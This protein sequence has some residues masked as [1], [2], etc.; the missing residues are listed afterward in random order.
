MEYVEKNNHIGIYK[1][2][3]EFMNCNSV[4]YLDNGYFI[5]C[6]IHKII[7]LLQKGFPMENGF[8]VDSNKVESY[9]QVKNVPA[10][11]K[12]Y[13]LLVMN[14]SIDDEFIAVDGGPA[15]LSVNAIV[16]V[17]SSHRVVV[18]EPPMDF[19]ANVWTE[20]LILSEMCI[21]VGDRLCDIATLTVAWS[22]LQ[23]GHVS[24]IAMAG[25]KN[26]FVMEMKMGKA[27]I[28]DKVDT[29][30]FG[31]VL[32]S[33]WRD[34]RLVLSS[35]DGYIL[36]Y[37][38]KPN[39]MVLNYSA[40]V[41]GCPTSIEVLKDYSVLAAVG[42]G[43][44]RIMKDQVVTC[45]LENVMYPISHLVARE[46]EDKVVLYTSSFDGAMNCYE[47]Q[48]DALVFKNVIVNEHG[49]AMGVAVSKNQTLVTVAYSNTSK[50]GNNV[51]YY[52]LYYNGLALKEE[53]I[54][55]Q[56]AILN[57]LLFENLDGLMLWDVSCLFYL[58]HM[59]YKHATSGNKYTIQ[60][61]LRSIQDQYTKLL[62][63]ASLSEW[64]NVPHLPLYRFLKLN[65]QQLQSRKMEP[66]FAANVFGKIALRKLN[67]M[68]PVLLDIEKDAALLLA[69]AVLLLCLSVKDLAMPANKKL[70]A[71]VYEVYKL[72]GKPTDVEWIQNINLETL[73]A[74]TNFIARTKCTIC[75][76]EVCS[77]TLVCQSGH[78][79]ERCFQ[80]FQ[81]IT[82]GAT[83]W[84]CQGCHASAYRLHTSHDRMPF[85]A[86][87]VNNKLTCQVCL[88]SCIIG[89]I[90]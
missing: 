2:N 23:N 63:K 35:V 86:D 69:D 4:F 73:G 39:G 26:M 40:L 51:D 71:K 36:E 65:C 53:Q 74:E 67:R 37:Q 75:Q 72:A 28:V 45:V 32:K 77:K 24:Y 90:M 78:E 59:K 6:S 84:Q 48:E 87:E 54:E 41:K 76:K 49:A 10:H 70:L 47:V 57:K 89:C 88:H 12:L 44:Y 21:N 83:N 27:R 62:K 7:C 20:K 58:L 5:I 64:V 61:I 17:S 50:N 13:R 29:E 1:M 79:M 56:Y 22:K 42:Y 68:P 81:M 30:K 55:G 11:E 80:T 33:A 34:D 16:T 15:A 14:D 8:F 31:W 85:F 43:I 66:V 60:P 18:Y 9:I 3:F 52:I 19:G 25:K 46:E 38:A 82:S